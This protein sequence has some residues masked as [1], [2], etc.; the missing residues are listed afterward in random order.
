MI[1]FSD[2]NSCHID[3]GEDMQNNFL[4]FDIDGTLKDFRTN[5]VPKSAS[6]AIRKAQGNGCLA[7]IASGRPRFILNEDFGFTPNGFIFASGAGFELNGKVVLSRTFDPK[8]LQELMRKAEQCHVSYNLQGFEGGYAS[9][10]FY[11]DF[12][13]EM[14]NGKMKG[15]LEDDYLSKGL[16]PMNLYHEEPIYKID[17]HYY[18]DSAKSTFMNWLKGRA[19]YAGTASMNPNFLDGAELSPVDVNKG[20]GVLMVVT[21]YHGDM[22][23]T[24]AFG[25]SL[26]DYEMIRTVRHGVAMSNGVKQLREIAE[27]VTDSPHEDGIAKS[28]FHYHLI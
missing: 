15:Y 25:D 7:F 18:K 27:Y 24:Y 9:P 14:T 8:L 6:D 1:L 19:E 11:H 13:D 4:F 23:K 3:T 12:E 22:E 16:R 20:T 10:H 28:L 17:I 26:N 2:N 21:H 5:G